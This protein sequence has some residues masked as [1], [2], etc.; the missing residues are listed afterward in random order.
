MLVC[1]KKY[2]LGFLWI[3]IPQQKLPIPKKKPTQFDQAGQYQC[4]L[5]NLRVDPSLV[6]RSVGAVSCA[7][8][9]RGV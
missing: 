4:L 6:K 2:K 9:T 8:V 3:H 5:K 1:M 7:K